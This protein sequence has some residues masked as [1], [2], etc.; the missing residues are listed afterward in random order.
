MFALSDLWLRRHWPPTR[1][2]SEIFAE[3]RRVY[4]PDKVDEV[5]AKYEVFRLA[6][7]K[8][9]APTL[10]R[11]PENYVRE[12]CKDWLRVK[13]PSL[14]TEGLEVEINMVLG[15]VLPVALASIIAISVIGGVV[16][17]IFALVAAGAA[18][19]MM[20]R[21]T[22]ARNIETEH[23]IINFLLA[24]WE[25]LAVAAEAASIKSRGAKG[26]GD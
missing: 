24:H 15:L 4:G 16:G 3:I 1:K 22:W 7:G 19:F 10:P 18:V 13:V 23:A 6:S 9:S 17:M 20:Y 2:L 26:C 12:F 25:S 14:H 8:G 21:I 5:A 11:P